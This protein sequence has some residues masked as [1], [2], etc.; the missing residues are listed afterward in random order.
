METMTGI[1][2]RPL[3]RLGF[4]H[5]VPFERD[6]P[7]R[8]LEEALELFEYAESLGLDGGW[9]RTRHIQYGLPSAAAFLAAASQRTTRIDLGT[10][11]IPTAYESP[12]RL[13]EDLAVADL[14]SGGRVQA[15]L[16][17]GAPKH[18]DAVADRILG[19]WRREDVS[20]ARIERVLSFIRGDRVDD[21]E[22]EIGFGGAAESS[23]DRVEPHSPGLASRIW[24]G[25]GSM[26][27][28][29]W[30]GT[31]GLR[32]LVSNITSGEGDETFA[33]AQSRQ[34]AAFRAHHPL[35]D[36]AV[37]SQGHVVLPLDGATPAQRRRYEEYAAARAPRTLAPLPSGIRIAPDAI[38]STE[39]IVA[40]LEADAGF[41]ASDE[42]LFELPFQFGPQD[43]RQILERMATEVGPALGWAPRR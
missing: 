18:T 30:A 8:G 11:V 34:I 39:E 28:A 31:A 33:E 24:Y 35:G 20:H 22:H 37:V 19:D 16:S 14:L 27:S 7:A 2:P 21:S 10:A 26:R 43:Y 32:L 13:A 29:T 3:T 15:G 5:I 41:A 40:R 1:R 17:T 42:F 12:L 9:V 25:S 23:S 38:G 6:D 4:L 36:A